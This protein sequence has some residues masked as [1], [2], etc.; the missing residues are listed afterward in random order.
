MKRLILALF[1]LELCCLGVA[2]E[3]SPVTASTPP[4]VSNESGLIAQWRVKRDALS[5]RGYDWQLAYKLDLFRKMSGSNKQNFG[6]DNLDIKL[7]LD[8]EKI[9]GRILG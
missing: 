4:V 9:A 5:E 3:S 2:A 1:F 7:S 6:L 8:G